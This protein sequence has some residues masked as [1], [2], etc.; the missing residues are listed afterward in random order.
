MSLGD[1]IRQTREARGIA[2]S[3]LARTL[4][5]TPKAV[6]RWEGNRM[7]PRPPMLTKIAQE[8]RADR[9][10]LASGGLG[11]GSSKVEEILGRAKADLAA[12]MNMPA[13]GVRLDMRVSA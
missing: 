1:R 5:V 7:T 11:T 4:G 8:L 2:V 3:D 9:Q 12:A 10:W 13:S 6:S